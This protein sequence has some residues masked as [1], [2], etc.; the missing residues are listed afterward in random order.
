MET[1]KNIL[2]SK[3][4]NYS[5]KKILLLVFTIAILTSWVGQQFFGKEISENML[6]QLVNIL[7]FLFTETQE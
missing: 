4:G 6:A 7:K 3:N 1:L 2:K 5:I